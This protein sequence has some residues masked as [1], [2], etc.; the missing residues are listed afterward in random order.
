MASYKNSKFLKIVFSCALVVLSLCATSMFQL[1]GAGPAAVIDEEGRPAAALS[2]LL[3]V[4]AVKHDGTL[5]SIVDATQK[6]WMRPAGTER[7]D[8]VDSLPAEIAERIKPLCI[9]LGLIKEVPPREKHYTYAFLLGAT[10]PAVIGRLAYLFYNWKQGVHFNKLVILAGQRDLRENETLDIVLRSDVIAIGDREM[11]KDK[12]KSVKTEKDMMQAII[13]ESVLPNGMR[14]SIAVE[15]VDAPKKLV[16]GKLV[17]P[18]TGDTVNAW[19]EKQPAPGTCI[20][21][22]S[23]PHVL[24][25]QA[26][27]ATLLPK[28]FPVE[29]IGFQE[30]GHTKITEILDA[31][32]RFLYQE[33][34]RRQ[35]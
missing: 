6:A 13:E 28:E 12:W 25:Q 30:K 7:W 2:R 3:S 4:L 24:Y 9:E 21:I 18:T 23:Q 8:L 34:K 11:L 14:E 26:V 31:L 1:D 32:A 19:L 22:S 33:N 5:Q 20:A 27:L 17:R 15:V 29:T 16:D 10:L 35:K